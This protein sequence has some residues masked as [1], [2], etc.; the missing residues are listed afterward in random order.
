MLYQQNVKTLKNESMTL[1]YQELGQELVTYN[2]SV[3]DEA[4]K[5]GMAVEYALN[6][7]RERKDIEN[8]RNLTSSLKEVSDL[9]TKYPNVPV[10]LRFAAEF[11]IWSDLTDAD[12][13]KSA[14]RYVSDYFKSRNSNVAIV[15][16]PNQVSNWNIDIDDF[17]PGDSYV[18]WVGMSL[19]AGKYF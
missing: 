17:Y 2:I 14:Y 9:I 19:Y 5:S 13:F 12:S 8:I 7:P 16:S 15:W 4:E 6:C 11:D 1:V 18:D 3:F 10:Y